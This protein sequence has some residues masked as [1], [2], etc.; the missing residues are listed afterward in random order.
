MNKQQ[1]RKQERH[2]AIYQF[3]HDNSPV[4]SRDIAKKFGIDKSTV[5][6]HIL[7]M[8]DDSLVDRMR[9][10]NNVFIKSK[11]KAF[12]GIDK[13]KLTTNSNS[14]INN[15]L[16]GIESAK[17]IFKHRHGEWVTGALAGRELKIHRTTACRIMLKLARAGMMERKMIEREYYYRATAPIDTEIEI[18]TFGKEKIV[19][20]KT[21]FIEMA[22]D[23]PDIIKNWLGYPDKNPIPDGVEV[24]QVAEKHATYEIARRKNYV[25]G[26]T[27]EML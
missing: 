6:I 17:R 7:K 12:R 23:M 10:G 11:N 2:E 13:S 15:V 20:N 16:M 1:K 26:G 18:S 19:I 4:Q 22:Q 8:Q 25:N 24:R 5:N 27:L 21:E 14:G 9:I 3:I